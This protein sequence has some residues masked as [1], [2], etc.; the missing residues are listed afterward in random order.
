MSS[1][2]SP[3]FGRMIWEGMT[4]EWRAEVV[5][6]KHDK[7]YPALRKLYLSVAAEDAEVLITVEQAL[8]V[9]IT[10]DLTGIVTETEVW[11]N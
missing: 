9:R 2:G 11:E 5:A 7:T 8:G 1:F 3:E 10:D 4:P 6:G